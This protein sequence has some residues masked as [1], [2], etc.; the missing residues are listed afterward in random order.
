[1]NHRHLLALLITCPQ[2]DSDRGGEGGEEE[3]DGGGG[4]REGWTGYGEGKPKTQDVRQH[5]RIHGLPCTL[6]PAEYEA[7]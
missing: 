5:L 2:A 7:V 4:D 6:Y 3:S 1:M